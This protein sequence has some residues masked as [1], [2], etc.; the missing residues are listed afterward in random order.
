MRNVG[1]K[2]Y[3]TNYHVAPSLSGVR[4]NLFYE[5]PRRPRRG[6]SQLQPPRSSALE[7]GPPFKR[8]LQCSDDVSGIDQGISDICGGKVA[9]ALR[10]YSKVYQHALGAV[11]AGD[12]CLLA[13]IACVSIERSRRPLTS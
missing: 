4:S 3:V 1:R 12:S 7:L 9:G 5:C 8:N 6:H 11:A 10:R 13:H 2:T